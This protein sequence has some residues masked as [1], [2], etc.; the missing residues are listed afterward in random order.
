MSNRGGSTHQATTHLLY[1]HPGLNSCLLIRVTARQFFG[2]ALIHMPRPRPPFASAFDPAL[3]VSPNSLR[4]RELLSVLRAQR[5]G[6]SIRKSEIWVPR[7][8]Y[9]K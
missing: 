4:R 9:D 7:L 3:F 2:I 8:A 5:S 6:L 1:P